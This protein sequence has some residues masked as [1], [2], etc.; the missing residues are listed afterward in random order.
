M[1]DNRYTTEQ[2][3]NN[4]SFIRWIEGDLNR[5]QAKQWD[6]WGQKSEKNRKLA[7][8]AQQDITGFSFENPDLPDVQREW[9]KIRNEIVEK[10][11]MKTLSR[12]TYGEKKRDPYN[13]FFK[14]AAAL[15]VG[16]FSAFSVYMYQESEPESEKTSC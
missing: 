14:V 8:E 5:R 7:I 3:L 10:K 4:S 15:L 11:Q 2:L 16:I 9:N 6:Q 12:K 1:E 13:F